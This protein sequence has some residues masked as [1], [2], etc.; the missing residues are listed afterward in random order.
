MTLSLIDNVT[1][2]TYLFNI[3]LALFIWNFAL[4]VGVATSYSTGSVHG[5]ALDVLDTSDITQYLGHDKSSP[6]SQLYFNGTTTSA[7]SLLSLFGALPI[8]FVLY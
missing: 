5:T 8:N 3:N 2:G 1:T 6:I 4:F 7:S